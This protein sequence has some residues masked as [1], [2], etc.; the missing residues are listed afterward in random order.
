MW[1]DYRKRGLSR[2]LKAAMLTK[3]LR[4]LPEARV[5][6]TGNANSNVPMLKINNELGFK[7]FISRPAWQV[8]TET[9]E[10]YLAGSA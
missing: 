3:I 7:P 9:V 5:I 10:K 4:E 8:E 1:P 6:R 2:W